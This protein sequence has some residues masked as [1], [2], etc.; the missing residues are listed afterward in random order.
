MHTYTY[1]ANIIKQKRSYQ[2]MSQGKGMRE[3]VRREGLEGRRVRSVIILFNLKTFRKVIV[4][5]I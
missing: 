3:E 2:F 1:V 5:K 4:H